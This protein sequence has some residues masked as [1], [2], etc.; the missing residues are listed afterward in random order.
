MSA[1]GILPDYNTTEPEVKSTATP[2]Q[3]TCSLDDNPPA[4]GDIVLFLRK[5]DAQQGLDFVL[6]KILKSNTDEDGTITYTVHAWH[7]FYP[8][9]EPALRKYA[10]AWYRGSGAEEEF[11]YALHPGDDQGWRAWTIDILPDHIFWAEDPNKVAPHN[12]LPPEV[13]KEL[14]TWLRTH[15]QDIGISNRYKFSPG[16]LRAAWKREGSLPKPAHM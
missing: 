7:G 8:F 6:G 15:R 3:K 2:G 12:G 1:S 10:P 14:P 4:V 16:R 11:R 9:E 13:V 5:E